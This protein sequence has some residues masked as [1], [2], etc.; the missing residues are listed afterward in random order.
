MSYQG[1]A[2]RLEIFVGVPLAPV[3]VTAP[4]G[5]YLL[6]ALTT[7]LHPTV[8]DHVDSLTPKDMLQVREP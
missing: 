1:P 4:L 3:L 2:V 6:Q 5:W 7:L 8:Q